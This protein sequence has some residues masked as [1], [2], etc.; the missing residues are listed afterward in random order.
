MSGHNDMT[1]GADSPIRVVV[2]II[3][4]AD[5][6]ILIAQ[7]RKTDTSPLKWEFPGGKAR[8]GESLEAALAREVEEELGAK[9][10]ACREI[11]S[12]RHQY[13]GRSEELEIHFCAAAIDESAPLTPRVFE[14]IAW[15]LP[16]ELGNYDFLAAN[17][18]LVAQLAT[19]RVKPAEFLER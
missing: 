5:R 13:A 16:R 18:P 15:A 10:S 14:Q 17:L 3:E 11:T 8:D 7:R 12:V 2:A 4:R 19:G 1:A 6:R 9:L